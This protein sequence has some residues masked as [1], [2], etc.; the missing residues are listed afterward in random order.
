MKTAGTLLEADL[1]DFVIPLGHLTVK[2][3]LNG[4]QLELCALHVSIINVV[5]A[6]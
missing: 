2:S 4:V 6:V 5:A 3:D 1:F